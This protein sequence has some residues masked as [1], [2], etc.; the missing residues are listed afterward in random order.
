MPTERTVSTKFLAEEHLKAEKELGKLRETIQS[1]STAGSQ[2][3]EA[4][5]EHDDK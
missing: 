2:Q 1:Y 5:A 4:H 3:N